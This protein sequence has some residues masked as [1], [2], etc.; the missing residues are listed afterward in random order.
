MEVLGKL[1][2]HAC[3][4]LLGNGQAEHHWKVTK[5]NKQGQRA[6]LGVVRTKKQSVIFAAN[7]HAKSALRRLA[8]SKAGKLYEDAD[9]DQFLGKGVWE[10][11]K[12]LATC[13]FRA[14]YRVW[15]DAQLN[16]AGN[17][18]FAAALSVKY[19]GLK[20]YDEDGAQQGFDG[21]V[22]GF[23]LGDSCCV[24]VK[25]DD[26]SHD[27]PMKKFG[28]QCC[29]LLYFLGFDCSKS[30]LKQPHKCWAIQ[31]LFKYCDFYGMI[32]EYYTE[33]PKDAE[34]IGLRIRQNDGVVDEL[35]EK[36]AVQSGESVKRKK[37]M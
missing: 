7:S 29:I 15:E 26:D 13:I 5:R 18:R 35:T 2:C 27:Q 37:M 9:F 4:T 12:R 21:P 24:L 28:Y 32:Q 34:E 10:D 19:G 23:T 1:R 33:N 22:N 17:D 25:L 16:S 31:E 20:F 30:Y 14:W 8:A 36:E 11:R 3:S 6:R